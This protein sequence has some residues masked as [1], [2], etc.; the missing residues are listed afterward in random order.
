MMT[1][2]SN[3][4]VQNVLTRSTTMETHQPKNPK[5]RTTTEYFALC[6]I[7]PAITA[8]CP[9]SNGGGAKVF[10]VANDLGNAL[11]TNNKTFIVLGQA[12]CFEGAPR[13]GSTSHFHGTVFAQRPEGPKN[14]RHKFALTPR[15]RL[16]ECMSQVGY[17][18]RTG[19]TELFGSLLDGL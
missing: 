6:P 8:G 10:G 19:D 4:I 15:S 3:G 5:G 13:G 17:R 9:H 12:K 2:I 7:M 11:R 14:T 16:I 1:R 18:G